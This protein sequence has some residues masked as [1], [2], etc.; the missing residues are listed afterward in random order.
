MKERNNKL[1]IIAYRKLAIPSAAAKLC[2][3]L[4]VFVDSLIAAK[5]INVGAVS[6]IAFVAPVIA[7][8]NA[9]FSLLG[10]GT[11]PVLMR[12]KSKG[13]MRESNRAF[14][15][16]MGN[17]FLCYI[18]ICWSS[19]SYMQYIFMLFTEDAGLIQDAMSYFIPIAI[20]EPF[21]VALLCF[22]RGLITEGNTGY[23]GFRGVITTVLN[24]AFVLIAVLLL[25]AGILGISIASNL[26]TL[27]GYCWDFPYYFSK[28]C[29]DRPDF[30]VLANR[31]EAIGYIKEG[32]KVGSV[33]ALNSGMNAIAAIWFNKAV[34]LTGGSAALAA[35]GIYNSIARIIRAFT[36]SVQATGF[37]LCN[38]FYSNKDYEGARFSFRF[39]ILCEAVLVAVSW[40][41]LNIFSQQIGLLF[42]ADTPDIL[43]ALQICFLF[44]TLS[45][46]ASVYSDLFGSIM[47]V[48][49]RLGVAQL[50][51]L[52]IG[53]ATLL[54]SFAGMMEMGFLELMIILASTSMLAALLEVWYVRFSKSNLWHANENQVCAYSYDL[55]E[56]IC[57]EIG[58]KTD[59]LLQAIPPVSAIS[60]K[61]ARIIEECH[62]SILR[63]N[64]SRRKKV[65]AD[66]RISMDNKQCVF[67]LIDTGIPFDPLHDIGENPLASHG[68]LPEQTAPGLSF[69]FSY[70]R[71]VDLNVSH[72]AISLESASPKENAHDAL[73]Q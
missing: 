30:S 70:S 46:A 25:D 6:A 16:I 19:I 54:G 39:A 35:I 50:F 15:A 53:A 38:L 36:L 45:A 12:Y 7:V 68:V 71:V 13:Q 56:S 34:I 9:L 26:A 3:A 41:I 69:N 23:F 57:S 20:C 43:Y 66:F 29:M 11:V 2:V 40:E 4:V 48:T 60:L 44:Y 59:E 33:D 24:I 62:R 27:L 14:A 32:I 61:T 5:F 67:T 52:S 28:R 22:E 65:S 55:D 8:D 21:C 42:H 63:V 72:V 37:N 31:V 1:I 47:V 49:N 64:A 51:S 17:V 73:P 58:R 18:A 10:S